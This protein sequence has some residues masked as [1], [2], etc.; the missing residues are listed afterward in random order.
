MS[1]VM[2]VPINTID[3]AR[4]IAGNMI[5]NLAEN[6]QFPYDPALYDAFHAARRFSREQTSNP[7]EKALD[8]AVT[9]LFN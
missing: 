9:G 7:S 8:L 5:C 1:K 2:G 3:S 4:A 6:L